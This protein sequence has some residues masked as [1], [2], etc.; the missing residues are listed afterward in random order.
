LIVRKKGMTLGYLVLS[1]F[2]LAMAILSN[3]TAVTAWVHSKG[4]RVV[5]AYVVSWVVFIL[6]A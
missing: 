2:F 6:F 1:I 4:T 3:W 5:I